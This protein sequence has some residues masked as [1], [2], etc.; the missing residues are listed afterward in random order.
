[1]GHRGVRC[2]G[3]AMRYGVWSEGCGVWGI[4]AWDVRRWGEGVWDTGH[5]VGDAVWGAGCG[6]CGGVCVR[7][8]SPG[9]TACDIGRGT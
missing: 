1:M 4:G 7:G 9:R 2:E 5:G 8:C 6:V 3:L